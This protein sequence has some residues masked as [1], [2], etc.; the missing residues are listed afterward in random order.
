MDDG[1][2]QGEEVPSWDVEA[3]MA[4]LTQQERD[5]VLKKIDY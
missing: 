1:V 5:A 2:W 3:V 4:D